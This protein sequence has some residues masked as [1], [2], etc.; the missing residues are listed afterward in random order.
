[1][2]RL[3]N[4]RAAVEQPKHKHRSIDPERDFSKSDSNESSP[5]ALDIRNV[6]SLDQHAALLGDTS[7]GK[8]SDTLRR[9]MVVRQL[10]GNFGNQYVSRLL[11]HVSR[12]NSTGVQAKMAVGPAGDRY[13]READHVAKQVLSQIKGSGEQP[14]QRQGTEGEDVSLVQMKPLQRQIGIE[15]GDV[16]GDVEASIDGSRGSG[17]PIDENVRRS[18]EGAFGADFSDVR[19]HSGSESTALNDSM[20]ARAFTTGKDIFFRQGE[21]NPGSD[22]GKEILAH[23]LTRV[24]TP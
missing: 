17:R 11:D 24:S 14:V 15:G 7:S 18:M 20:S 5:V 23:E 22:A 8:L 12:R 21:Y 9:A 19:V 2:S 1:M 13:E 10:Q 16:S 4:N 6:G 3:K